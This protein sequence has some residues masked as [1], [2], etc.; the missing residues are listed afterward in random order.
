MIKLTLL[1]FIV[2]AAHLAC[3]LAFVE[4]IPAADDFDVFLTGTLN[5]IEEA[6]PLD[7]LLGLFD[8]HGEHFVAVPKTIGLLSYFGLGEVNFIALVV[9]GNLFLFLAALFLIRG[10]RTNRAAS[11]IT[12]LGIPFLYF[13]PQIH[14][15]SVWATAALSNMGVIFFALSSLYY[16]KRENP[17]PIRSLLFATLAFLTQAN[18]LLVFALLAFNFILAGKKKYFG[19]YCL[20]FL[21]LGFVKKLSSP[22]PTITIQFQDNLN[23]FLSLLG[24]PLATSF[25]QAIGLGI[26]VLAAAIISLGV[27]FKLNRFVFLSLLFFLLSALLAS[28]MRLHLGLGGGFVESRYRL[29]SCSIMALSAIAICIGTRKISVARLFVPISLF[30]ASILFYA[31]SWTQY[32]DF[33]PYLFSKHSNSVTRYKTTGLGLNHPDQNVAIPIL[34]KSE[35]SKIYSLPKVAHLTLV[36]PVKQEDFRVEEGNLI[37]DFEYFI[38]SKDQLYMEGFVMPL[39]KVNEQAKISVRLV[40]EN[41]A[42]FTI[43]TVQ[44]SRPDLELYFGSERGSTPGFTVLVEKK[45]LP[46][47]KYRTFLLLGPDGLK[48]HFIETGKTLTVN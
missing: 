45:N 12:L 6:N 16:G 5:F 18:G 33:Y 41:G 8:S 24:A 7:K 31:W 2:F 10:A 47:G 28:V 42:A 29:V 27:S 1:T 11:S 15:S 40:N 23:Y 36:Q 35:A 9:T 44:Y 19:I 26:Y 30:A 46:S 48:H 39:E 37:G 32:F 34:K 21:A 43:Q 3:V 14:Q 25:E 20:L 22:S 17:A 13:H 4:N 38:D